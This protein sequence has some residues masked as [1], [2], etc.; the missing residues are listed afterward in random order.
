M[1][2]R[3][4]GDVHDFYK[5]L[6]LKYL[7]KK[8]KEKIGLNWYLVSP[9]QVSLSEDKKKDGEKRNYLKNKEIC[10]LDSSISEEFI[11]FIQIEKRNIIDFTERTHLKRY[12]KFYNKKITVL[13][14][15]SWF[16]ESLFFLKIK[17]LYFLI[18]IMVY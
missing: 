15:K 17:R 14:R 12:I 3:Y 2:E 8:L 18:Q 11:N 1:Q 10:N 6:F 5:F 9:K 13:Q 4:L 7:S 16:Q